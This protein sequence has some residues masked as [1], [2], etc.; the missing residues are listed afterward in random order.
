MIDFVEQFV[1][2]N[3]FKDDSWHS[4]II[5]YIYLSL[6][7][8]I[9]DCRSKVKSIFHGNEYMISFVDTKDEC[10]EL[11]DE[12]MLCYVAVFDTWNLTNALNQLSSDYMETVVKNNKK[13]GR[14]QLGQKFVGRCANG[15]VGMDN[16]Y[17]RKQHS[18]DLGAPYQ[19][20]SYIKYDATT[21]GSHKC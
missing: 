11:C 9:R 8:A 10:Q 2:E 7:W 16:L 17:D 14:C 15:Y 3:H 4:K 1:K 13:F 19:Y 21:S 12:S 18:F 5:F 20:I 6:G